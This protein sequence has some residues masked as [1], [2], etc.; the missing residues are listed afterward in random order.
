[1][2]KLWYIITTPYNMIVDHI[3]FKRKMQ[4]LKKRDPFI[5]K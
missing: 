4:E 5:Y 2:K 3:R 1:M